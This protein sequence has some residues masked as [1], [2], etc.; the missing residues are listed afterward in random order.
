MAKQN[1]ASDRASYDLLAIDKSPYFATIESYN[2]IFLANH[3]LDIYQSTLDL[4]SRIRKT[5]RTVHFAMLQ[6]AEQN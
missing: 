5:K 6:I 2:C 1:Y 3:E 4:Y